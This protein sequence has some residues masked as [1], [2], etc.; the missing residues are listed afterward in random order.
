MYN[1]GLPDMKLSVLSVHFATAFRK[2]ILGCF[3]MNCAQE[4]NRLLSS[5]C[6]YNKFPSLFHP[7]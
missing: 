6:K 4:S 1:E 2:L 3:L 7:M 5:H